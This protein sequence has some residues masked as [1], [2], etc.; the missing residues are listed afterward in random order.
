MSDLRK[1]LSSNE[2][3][4]QKLDSMT[5][6]ITNL[7]EFFSVFAEDL[8]DKIDLLESKID[9]IESNSISIYKKIEDLSKSTTNP[10]S[11]D[12]PKT[13]LPPPPPQLSKPVVPQKPKIENLRGKIMD[14]LKE[15]FKRAK[16]R[17]AVEDDTM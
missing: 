6:L 12:M 15:Q 4:L 8:N 16:L 10:P 9:K 17:E 5:I 11:L 14:E 1:I 7:V 13:L 3:E 2:N